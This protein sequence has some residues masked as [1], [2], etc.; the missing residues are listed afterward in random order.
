MRRTILSVQTW[1]L[2]CAWLLIASLVATTA[3][4]DKKK[5][6]NAFSSNTNTEKSNNNEASNKNDKEGEEDKSGNLLE[7][8]IDMVVLDVAVHDRD[9]QIVGGL[10]KDQFG[11]WEDKIPQKIEF[12][13][14]EQIPVSVGFVIDTSGSMR[15][16]L[17][18][19]LEATRTMVSLA[20]PGDEFFVV[21]FKNKAYLTEEFTYNTSEVLEALS[22]LDANEG[23]ALL[24]AIFLAAD[25]AHKEA[26]NRR[27]ALVV[28]SDGDERDSFYKSPQL[29]DWLR[30]QDVQLYIIGFPDALNDTKGI[31]PI[32]VRGKAVKL[33]TE[34][35]EESGGRAFFPTCL[36]DVNSLTQEIGQ[37]IHSQYTIGY[38][39]SNEKQ[40]GSWRRVQVKLAEKDKTLKNFAVRSRTGYFAHKGN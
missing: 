6:A 38:F 35:A 18:S 29:L 31:F 21:N 16:K 11:I 25:Y 7:M 1:S 37:D 40:D 34:L 4:N 9:R 28:V 23:T 2:V 30:E 10:K 14:Q 12:F 20:R 15:S 36:F 13:S 26:K 17:P 33:M 3:A 5:Q 8:K 39:S 27:K 22:E 19:V 24:D 32:S